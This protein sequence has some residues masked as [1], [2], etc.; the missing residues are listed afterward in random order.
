MFMKCL[1]ASAGGIRPGKGNAET[2]MSAVR[3]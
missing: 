1:P 2:G 3:L